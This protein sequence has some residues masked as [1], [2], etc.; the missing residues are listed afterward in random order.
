MCNPIRGGKGCTL[1]KP[2]LKNKLNE[3][4]SIYSST[5]S[6][7][8]TQS[9][10]RN[11]AAIS[12]KTTSAFFTRIFA[13]SVICSLLTP[14][15]NPFFADVSFK[16][17]PPTVSFALLSKIALAVIEMICCT[18]VFV[19]LLFETNQWA[20]WNGESI[21]TRTQRFLHLDSHIVL[22]RI[23]HTHFV[24]EMEELVWVLFCTMM[25]PVIMI[26]GRTIQR[27]HAPITWVTA[28]MRDHYPANEAWDVTFGE[29]R[30][31]RGVLLGAPILVGEVD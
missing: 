14:L 30:H 15:S 24:Q 22:I 21:Q 31:N 6:L 17:L 8:L 11:R 1:Y 26:F 29:S 20:K 2:R 18:I 12:F 4:H 7:N 23:F 9:K 13:D 28:M 5:C 27:N 16:I 10:V 25:L 19:L 3:F